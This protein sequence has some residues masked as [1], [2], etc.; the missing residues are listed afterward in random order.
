M[1]WESSTVGCAWSSGLA[2]HRSGEAR[3]P[4]EAEPGSD[5]G[6]RVLH[7]WVDVTSSVEPL[8]SE[9]PKLP[10]VRAPTASSSVSS[11]DTE[12][13]ACGKKTTQLQLRVS[14]YVTT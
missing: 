11:G 10:H 5:P 6:E 3:T 13:S 12:C 2:G 14:R 4:S 8:H 9:N 7:L 1:S